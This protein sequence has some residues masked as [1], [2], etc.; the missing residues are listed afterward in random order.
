ML[1]NAEQNNSK[2]QSVSDLLASRPAEQISDHPVADY[3]KAM[4]NYPINAHS[5]TSQ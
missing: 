4:R 3:I 1:D 2:A 5:R